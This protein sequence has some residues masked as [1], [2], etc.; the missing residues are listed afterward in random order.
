MKNIKYSKEEFE[1]YTHRFIVRLSIDDDQR[2]DAS[3]H[4]FSNSDN[5]QKLEDFIKEKKSGK[6]KSFNI[7][8]RSSKEQD[9]LTAKFIE[10]TLKDW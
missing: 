7:V 10:E 3:L 6:V 4:I 1:G 8:H 9:V 5:Y 2:N